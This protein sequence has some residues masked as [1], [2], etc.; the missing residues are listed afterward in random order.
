MD[1]SAR[2]AAGLE[3]KIRAACDAV[4]G[5]YTLTVR[6]SGDPFLTEP[7]D[8]IQALGRVADIKDSDFLF[9]AVEQKSRQFGADETRTSGYQCCH[10]YLARILDVRECFPLPK[11]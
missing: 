11:T 6:N 7:G 8:F 2:M 5:D 9:A 4:G 1:S 10:F 3:A